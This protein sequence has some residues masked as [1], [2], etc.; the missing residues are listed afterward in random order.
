MAEASRVKYL[1]E[2]AR[3]F[4]RKPAREKRNLVR[5]VIL[6]FGVRIM[7]LVL[8]FKWLAAILGEQNGKA[9]SDD[10]DTGE[11]NFQY[12]DM[13]TRQIRNVSHVVPWTSNCLVQATVGKILLR[14]KSIASTVSFGVKKNHNK[15]EAHAWLTVGPRIVLGGET[16]DQFVKVSSFS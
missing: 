11:I 2:M 14:K 16:A 12:V 10:A 1:P 13:V 3:I 8:P 6:S 7:V 4:F 9:D 15:M 5:I